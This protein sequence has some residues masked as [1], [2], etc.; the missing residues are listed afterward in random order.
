[1]TTI[2]EQWNNAWFDVVD[3]NDNGLLELSELEGVMRATGMDLRAAVSWLTHMNKDSQGGI[4]RHE[5]VESEHRFWYK[6]K[7]VNWKK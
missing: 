5:Y 6:A 3:F 1:M 2:L 4:E 7:G